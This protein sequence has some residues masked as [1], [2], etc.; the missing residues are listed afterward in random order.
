MTALTEHVVVTTAEAAWGAYVP[1]LRRYFAKR[2]PASDVDDLVQEVFLRIQ[3]Q[4][5][6]GALIEQSSHLWHIAGFHGAIQ[7]RIH[8][9]GE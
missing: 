6:S 2:V 1:G 9:S 8:I 5:S 4:K 7:I 3:T